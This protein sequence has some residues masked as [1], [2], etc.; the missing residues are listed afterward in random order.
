MFETKAAELLNYSNKTFSPY[1]R[2]ILW[3]VK[4]TPTL[5]RNTVIVIM[6]SACWKLFYYKYFNKLK[7]AA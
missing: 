6:K 2:A 3:A 5:P 1:K 7:L 4:N